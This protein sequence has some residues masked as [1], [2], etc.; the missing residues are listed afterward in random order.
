[1]QSHASGE[2]AV[3]DGAGVVQSF[4]AGGCHVDGELA[5]FVFVCERD[6]CAFD[7]FSSVDPHLRVVDQ[8]VGEVREVKEGCQ[9][10]SNAGDARVGVGDFGEDFG[11]SCSRSPVGRDDVLRVFAACER[12]EEVVIF[13]HV[14]PRV[15]GCSTV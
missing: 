8:D 3:D 4:P 6:V 9:L 14:S 10:W 2:D 7:S 15:G 11:E 1:M 13:A 12:S 5:G